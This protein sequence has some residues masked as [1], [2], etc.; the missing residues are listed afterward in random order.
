MTDTLTQNAQKDD[1]L[2]QLE[3]DIDD[4]FREFK[5]EVEEMIWLTTDDDEPSDDNDEELAG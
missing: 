4:W 1:L 5:T 2:F 3:M